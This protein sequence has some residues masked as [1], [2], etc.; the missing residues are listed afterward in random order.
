M[1]IYK[2][3]FDEG[4][5]IA[6][7]ATSGKA[8]MVQKQQAPMQKPITPTP[9][10]KI[11]NTYKAIESNPV[12]KTLTAPQR[13]MTAGL[14]KVGELLGK[15][16]KMVQDLITGGKGY[17][18]F[19]TSNPVGKA[20]VGASKSKLTQAILPPASAFQTPKRASLAS[21][22]AL[23]PLNLV[24]AGIASKV[25]KAAK[26]PEFATKIGT[27]IGKSKLAQ[28]IQ[29]A[30]DVIGKFQ[31]GYG[32]A[33]KTMKQYERLQGEIPK[34]LDYAKDLAS[35]LFY[36]KNGKKLSTVEQKIIGD[37]MKLMSEG[38]AR[39]LTTDEIATLKK[40]EPT[41]KRVFKEFGKLADEQIK[42][43]A[44]PAIFERMMGKY[45]GQLSYSKKISNV[46]GV[47]KGVSLETGVYKKRQMLSDEAKKSLGQ[48]LEPAYGA[49]TAAYKEKK[50]VAVLQFF[51]DVAKNEGLTKQAFDR[52][53]DVS[54]TKYA[55]IS[56]D[57]KYGV[58]AGSYIPK[59]TAEY[60]KPLV[61]KAPQGVAKTAENI[62]K[63]FKAGKTV[64]SPKQLGRNVLTSQVQNFLENPMSLTYL[65]KAIKEKITGG[66]FYKALKNTGEIAQS[67]PSQELS[68]FLPDELAKFTKGG[69]ASKA[70]S[71]LKKPGSAIQ[72]GTE[73]V[74]KLQSF[75]ARM[76][77]EAGKARIPIEEALKRRDII[78]KAR[79][80]A[81]A[82]QFNYQKVSPTVAKLRKG[83]IPFITYP[84]KAAEL[85]AKTI[86]KN[87]ERITA[88]AKGEK[89]IQSSFQEP[90]D[91]Q[92]LPEYLN[93]AVRVGNK[94]EK[95]A[96]PYVNTKYF[97]PYGNLQDVSPLPFGLGPNP[98]ISE[99]AQ[100][101]LDKDLLT[102][103]KPSETGRVRHAIEAF[104]P[105]IVRS[106]WQAYDAATKNQ[107]YATSSTPK[108]VAIKETGLPW[109]KYSP[110][111]GESF[112]A[113]ETD[114][115]VDEIEKQRKKYLRDY[116]GK[117][118]EN[119]INKKMEYFDSLID[120]LYK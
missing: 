68:S 48:I 88:L 19:Y 49:A 81:E 119:E 46:G 39:A 42:A 50:N 80:A 4:V 33:P 20:I 67:M 93:K 21:E 22:I 95:G 15:P 58:L 73:E 82:S 111:E 99:T 17:E 7:E 115:K 106:M 63:I 27:V 59:A 44:D 18:D 114:S 65:P 91:E 5:R 52:L 112:S 118:S 102:G 97:Y 9:I 40:Y 43:G 62:T 54:K 89:A 10:Q 60:V 70:F 29:K 64:G 96:A 78:E 117:K 71:M 57:S 76:Y 85:T 12:V 23:D 55:L 36:G 1:G 35:P 28:P 24:G 37:S 30:R 120:K 14:G 32:V 75:M 56:N 94:D 41:I 11:A 6:G 16:Q 25:G 66:K 79:Q 34:A 77:D 45:G 84:T 61:D 83:W 92:Y 69:M 107:P 26:F 100:Q 47:G 51:K 98:L 72:Q 113:Y 103:K 3:A 105:S 90:I 53:D 108:D 87:P 13:T 109:Y 8:P 116:D 74:S 86:T 2:N 104:S 110:E 101:V 38:S 31:Y